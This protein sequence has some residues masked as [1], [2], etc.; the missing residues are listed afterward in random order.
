MSRMPG[1]WREVSIVDVAEGGFF[2]DG[3]WVETKDQDAAGS[4]R[5]T[6]L[7]DVGE[8]TFRDRSDRWMREDQAIRLNCTRLSPGDLLIARMPHP[9]ARCAEVPTSIGTA[10]TAVDVSV[11]RVAREDVCARFVMWAIN[12][13]DF[14]R[15][16]ERLQS[17]TTRK[18]ISRKNLGSLTVPLPPLDEQQRIVSVLEDHLSRLDAADGYLSAAAR[19]VRTLGSDCRPTPQWRRRV[20]RRVPS[21]TLS[22]ASRPEDRSEDLPLQRRRVSGASSGSAR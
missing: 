3:D 15:A 9:L 1:S 18:R 7:A 19:R 4:V 20:P 13:P 12:S 21:A 2:V 10:V 6:Q 8:A 11:L 22:S 16:A 17:G 14:R 5:L